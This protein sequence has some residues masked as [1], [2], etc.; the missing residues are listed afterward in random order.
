MLEHSIEAAVETLDPCDA[1][2]YRSLIAPL[3]SDFPELSEEILGPIQHTYRHPDVLERFGCL[4]LLTQHLWL[5]LIL[6]QNVPK[7]F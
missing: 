3:A 7:P 6:P 5:V 2:R 1:S 4:A